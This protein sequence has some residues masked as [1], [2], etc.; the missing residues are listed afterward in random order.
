MILKQIKKYS[1][2]L[3]SVYIAL[4]RFSMFYIKNIVEINLIIKAI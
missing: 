1:Y 3:K 2:E 4:K